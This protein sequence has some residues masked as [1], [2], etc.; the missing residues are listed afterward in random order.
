MNMAKEISTLNRLSP[1]QLRERYAEVFGERS[2][3]GNKQFLVKRIAWRL[4]ANEHGGLSQ[5]A[6]QRAAEL[7][8]D[9][10]LRLNPPPLPIAR[11]SP[12]PAPRSRYIGDGRLPGVGAVI[13]REYR[14]RTVQ[15]KVVEGGFEFE[16]GVHRSLSAVAK[17]ICGS[18]CNGFLFFNLLRRSA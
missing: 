10:H 17:A 1:A 13:T 2:R 6:L 3:S 14:G 5:R 15:V 18:H 11:A 16:G 9:S 8:A 12:S 4:Q 7:S